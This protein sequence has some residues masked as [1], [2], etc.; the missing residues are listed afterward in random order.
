MK[1]NAFVL[2]SLATLWT[3]AAG[4]VMTPASCLAQSKAGKPKQV[5]ESY[6]V[7]QI[8]DEIKVITMA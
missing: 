5:V 1:R 4:I 2:F 6:A 3:I 8:G 7:V